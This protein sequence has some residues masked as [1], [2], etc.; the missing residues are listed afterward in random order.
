MGSTEAR[1]LG[2]RGH[3]KREKKNLKNYFSKNF[4]NSITRRCG[5]LSASR[6]FRT[7]SRVGARTPKNPEK[8]DFP[9]VLFL[10]SE[11]SG[12]RVANNVDLVGTEMQVRIL[13][14]EN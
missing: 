13:V 10:K 6:A 7:I 11:V 9:E 8:I 1:R 12:G 4:R 2:A 3:R 5:T 14:E